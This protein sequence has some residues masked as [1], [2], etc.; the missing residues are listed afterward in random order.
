MDA[1]SSSWFGEFDPYDEAAVWARLMEPITVLDV[2][3]NEKV[4]LSDGP[5]GSRKTTDAH[6][7]FFY[8][9]SVATTT[10][11]SWSRA[12]CAPGGSKL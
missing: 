5:N 11:M 12:G 1:I 9:E 7:G 8:G 3:S 6:R 10:A 2:G 4:Y